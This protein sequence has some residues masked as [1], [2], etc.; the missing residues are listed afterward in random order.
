MSSIERAMEHGGQQVQA[1][2]QP[3]INEPPAS[4]AVPPA[5]PNVDFPDEVC[6]LNLEFL[7]RQGYLTPKLARS[8]LAEE[9][10]MIK[11]PLLINAFGRGAAPVERGNL[12]MVTSALPGEGKTFTSMNLAMSMAMERDNTVLLVDSDVVK[13]TLTRMLGL[14]SRQGL[15]DALLDP[16]MDLADIIVKPDLPNLRILPAGRTHAHSTE[17]LASTQMRN[18]ATELAERYPDR[19]VIFDA[20]PLLATSEASVVARLAGQIMVVVEE[21]RTPQQAVLDA[22]AQLDNQKV[23]G[24]ILNKD[25]RILSNDYYGGYY[26]SYGQQ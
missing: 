20:P 3:K 13:P 25:R 26:G 23:I 9:Y 5:S 10:R 1:K 16:Q 19:V 15:I 14:D 22:L 2:P 7:E 6:H 17:L 18:M 8:Q 24:M 11:R 21:G 12:I 4:P